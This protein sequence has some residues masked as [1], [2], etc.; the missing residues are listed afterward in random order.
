MHIVRN[1]ENCKV[2]SRVLKKARILMTNLDWIL[3]LP[4]KK[5]SSDKSYAYDRQDSLFTLDTQQTAF[6]IFIKDQH[7]VRIYVLFVV[8]R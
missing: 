6:V 8:Y 4:K 5:T 2:G 1:N 7:D 3:V